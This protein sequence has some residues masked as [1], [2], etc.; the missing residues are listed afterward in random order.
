MCIFPTM[1]VTIV[2][3][4]GFLSWMYCSILLND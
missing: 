4:Y 2:G 1:K 3:E